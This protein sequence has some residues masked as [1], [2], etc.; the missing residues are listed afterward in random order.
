[1][2]V[3]ESASLSSAETALEFAPNSAFV[4]VS[5]EERL[6]ADGSVAHATA[7]GGSWAAQAAA[8]FAAADGGAGASAKLAVGA[9]PFDHRQPAHL[10]LPREVRRERAGRATTR[11]AGQPL[12]RR[13]HATANPTVSDY[14]RQVV[15]VLPRLA[16]GAS[17]K[18]VLAR[19]LRLTADAPID[20]AALFDR[21]LLDPSI[22]AFQ[23]PLPSPAG[24]APRTL[25]GATP[26]L[27]VEKRGRRVASLPLAG[28]ARRPPDATADRAVADGLRRSTKDAREHAVV[29][30]WIA[31]RLTPYC[32]TLSVPALP[33][34]QSTRT[35]WHLASHI[36]GE[37][38]DPGITAI[39]LAE[40]L[41]PTPAVCGLPLGEALRDIR[42]VETF[43]RDFFGGAVGWAER[44]GDGS[45]WMTLRCAD[46]TGASATLYAGAGI[47]RGS[48]PE[49]EAAE[50]SAKL[51]AMLESLGV[52]E[53]GHALAIG[54]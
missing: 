14:A 11:I 26:E 16:T 13:W 23:V 4:I 31:D 47:V 40:M 53:A 27:L 32:R 34:L 3:S 30:E 1:M 41:H 48:V 54:S 52:D 37:L 24:G 12:G 8:L 38:A 19:S 9:L 18:I 7:T 21:L 28:S 50:T 51:M 10:Y 42:T 44:G 20:L 15:S 5:E 2:P 25:I 49:E 46:I 29:V 45:W 17:T 43:E 6:T 35:M 36:E 33:S 39:A 22:T